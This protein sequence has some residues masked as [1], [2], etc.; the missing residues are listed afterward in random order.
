MQTLLLPDSSPGLEEELEFSRRMEDLAK[1][2]LPGAEVLSLAL[3]T[4]G[5]VLSPFTVLS[6][7][8]V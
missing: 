4:P 1:V 5:P 8:D 6:L 3:L 7:K 2:Q